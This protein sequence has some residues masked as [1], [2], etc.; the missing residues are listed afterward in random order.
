MLEYGFKD[1]SLSLHT[2]LYQINMAE[3]YW[4]DGIHEKK[5]IFELFS[6][7]FRLKMVMRYLQAWKKPSNTWKIL[8]LRI[9]T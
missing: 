9:V 6:E 7:G 5:A 1:D 2:D 4:R 3:T 8:S